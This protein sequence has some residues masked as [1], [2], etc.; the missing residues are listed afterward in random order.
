[1]CYPLIKARD[2]DKAVITSD[3]NVSDAFPCQELTEE[4]GPGIGFP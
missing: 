2:E 3:V 1:M 4:K